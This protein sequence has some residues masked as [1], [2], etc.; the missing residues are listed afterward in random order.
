[1]DGLRSTS[2]RK[3]QREIRG[4]L[5]S[6]ILFGA[7]WVATDFW[8]FGLIALFAGVAPLVRGG[9]RYFNALAA[10][11]RRA[12][13]LPVVRARVTEQ[14]VLQA[15]RAEHGRVTPVL[16]AARFAIPIEEAEKTLEQL[17]SKGYASVDVNDEGRLVYVFPEFET[18]GRA[19]DPERIP[20]SG[21]ADRGNPGSDPLR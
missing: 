20:P 12:K 4:G 18:G 17:A 15:A 3:A 5:G 7:L 19:P 9:V 6:T 21:T 2:R 8:G 16:V 10:E 14:R 11:R 13:E 1:M